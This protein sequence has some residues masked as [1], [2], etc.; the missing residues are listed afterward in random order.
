MSIDRADTVCIG[1]DEVHRHCGPA[2]SE[3]AV[4]ADQFLGCGLKADL[5]TL[6]LTVPAVHFGFLDAFVEVGD[7]LDKARAGVGV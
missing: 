4:D 6:D 2:V 3:G 7:D 1:D 5:K